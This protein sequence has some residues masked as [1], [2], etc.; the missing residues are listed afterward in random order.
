MPAS[1]NRL[2]SPTLVHDLIDRQ[3]QHTLCSDNMVTLQY[4]ER[5][6][7]KLPLHPLIFTTF[8][9]PYKIAYL[10]FNPATRWARVAIWPVGVMAYLAALGR[11]GDPCM[12]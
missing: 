11:I 2:V 7:D 1:R 10:S 6:A 9:V 4:L 8:A 3:K 12:F 5:Q